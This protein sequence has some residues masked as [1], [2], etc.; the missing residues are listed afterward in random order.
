MRNATDS[1]Q[2]ALR[3]PDAVEPVHFIA[4]LRDVHFMIGVVG[5][6][7]QARSLHQVR[8]RSWN[9]DHTIAIRGVQPVIFLNRGR[10]RS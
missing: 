7:H 4:E 2:V 8:R 10:Y 1:L 9:K 3:K 6:R 5:V